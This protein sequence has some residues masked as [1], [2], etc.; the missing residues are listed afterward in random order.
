MLHAGGLVVAAAVDLG[1]GLARA[2][3]VLLLHVLPHVFLAA[4]YKPPISLLHGGRID[5]LRVDRA[6]VRSLHA[7]PPNILMASTANTCLA[8]RLVETLGL[9]L[10]HCS[11]LG[12]TK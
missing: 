3:L 8:F 7:R 2:S 5:A 11:T 12:V 6:C 9:L 1:H 4:R 10:S